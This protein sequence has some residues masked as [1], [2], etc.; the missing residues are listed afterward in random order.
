MTSVPHD[1]RY[2]DQDVRENDQL[3][4]MA[5]K[6]L[7]EYGGEFDPLVEAKHALDGGFELTTPMLR[8]VLN[9]MRHDFKVASKMPPPIR[10]MGGE[11]VSTDNE[12]H[13]VAARKIP[14]QRR[15]QE[16]LKRHPEYGYPIQDC[17]ELEPHYPHSWDFDEMRP[18]RRWCEGVPWAINREP[19]YTR[20]AKVHYKFAASQTGKLVHLLTG[21][22]WVRWYTNTHGYGWAN[23]TKPELSVDLVCLYPSIL[24][25]PILFKEEPVHLYVAD[26]RLGRQR[27]PH[28]FKE[29][30]DG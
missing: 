6:Y 15:S 12:G 14:A 23:W 1:Y 22:G 21:I 30:N 11:V 3:R 16:N 2:T 10:L 18:K 24:R 19:N 13:V 25:N 26:P 28:C 17:G 9:C 20:P 8:K 27:C 7:R 29:N 5:V 4:E